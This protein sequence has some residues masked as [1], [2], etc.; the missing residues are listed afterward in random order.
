MGSDDIRM[1]SSGSGMGQ[2]AAS[3]ER[4]YEQLGREYLNLFRN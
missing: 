3:Q 1:N 4:D 2:V